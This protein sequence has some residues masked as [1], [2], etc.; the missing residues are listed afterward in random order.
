MCHNL[1]WRLGNH[2]PA[3]S[4]HLAIITACGHHTR[5]PTLLPPNG[6]CT[7]CVGRPHSVHFMGAHLMGCTLCVDIHTHYHT[8]RPH[9]AQFMGAHFMGCTSCAWAVHT[10]SISWAPISWAALCAWTYIHTIIQAVHTP[11]S[12]WVPI[13]W[14]APRAWTILHDYHMPDSVA[15]HSMNPPYDV[16]SPLVC[17]S[18]CMRVN[19]TLELAVM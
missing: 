14:A 15:Q 13:S 11:P 16:C 4:S 7:S 10:P 12:S 17:N 19:S 2:G 1:A 3:I 5:T 6:H 9:S 18:E 8:G